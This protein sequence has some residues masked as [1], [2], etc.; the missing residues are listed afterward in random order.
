MALNKN[1]SCLPVTISCRSFCNRLTGSFWSI[2]L[3]AA[4][5]HTRVQALQ[6]VQ[7]SGL[8]VGDLRIYYLGMPG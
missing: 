7:K 3:M 6:L 1:Y 2:K 8:I 5:G 4:L